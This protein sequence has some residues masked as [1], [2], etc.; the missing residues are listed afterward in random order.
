MVAPIRITKIMLVICAVRITIG[1]QRSRQPAP[2]CAR[3]E[4][5]GAD[6]ADRGRFGR[7]RDAAEDRAQHREDQEE[8][9]HQHRAGAC[10]SAR[11][12][13]APDRAGSAGDGWGK[14]IATAIR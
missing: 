11:P 5:D 8:R 4:Q 9:R 3:R 14:K 10:D 7:R 6:R 2:A 1:D 13:G 12:R